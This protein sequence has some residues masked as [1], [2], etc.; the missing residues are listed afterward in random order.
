M[1]LKNRN[2]LKIYKKKK[3]IIA[4]KKKKKKK[5]K[6]KKIGV[7]VGAENIKKIGK[8]YFKL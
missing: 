7:E 2:K 1:R 3:E 6:I 5:K 4:A 8:K